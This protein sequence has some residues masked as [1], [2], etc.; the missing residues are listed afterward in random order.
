[1]SRKIGVRKN[2]HLILKVDNFSWNSEN[3]KIIAAFSE[4]L[5]FSPRRGGRD[6]RDRSPLNSD[7]GRDRERDRE[8]DRDRDKFR[9]KED[10]GPT[11]DSAVDS[12]VNSLKKISRPRVPNP[13]LF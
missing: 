9:K 12:Y 2:L 6:V 13:G 5:F 11:F 4:D 1:M 3:I 10:Q 8:R 7:R